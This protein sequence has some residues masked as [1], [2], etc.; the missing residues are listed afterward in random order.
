MPSKGLEQLVE[1]ATT[2]QAFADRLWD[3]PEAVLAEYDLTEEE[4][5][6]LQSR[7]PAQ[8]QAVGVDERASKGFRWS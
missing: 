4:K 1:R 5:R 8:L 6:A 3:E 2:D 7:D